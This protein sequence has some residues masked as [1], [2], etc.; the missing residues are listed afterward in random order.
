[1]NGLLPFLTTGNPILL[2]PPF[3]KITI[4][5]FLY[6]NSP[7]IFAARMN[8]HLGHL[9]FMTQPTDK[10]LAIF[11]STLTLIREHGFHGTPMSLIAK[12]AGVAAGTIYHHFDSKDTLIEELYEHVLNQ[13]L[14]SLLQ[15]DE[16]QMNYK[17]RFFNFFISHC[18][19]YMEHPTALFF[20]EQFVNSPYNNRHAV[21]DNERGQGSFKYLIKYGVDQQ[22]LK[23]VDYRILGS[24][25]LGCIAST[26][27][28]HLCRNIPLGK[29]ELEQIAQMVWDGMKNPAAT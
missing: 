18:L 4:F 6:L 24:L 23:P 1:V 15:S 28:V 2:L 21:Q 26:A 3:P 20:I 27:K 10:K 13:I 19:F 17:D 25:A 16:V 8:V 5:S 9:Y 22:Y 29:A 12:K 7:G 11:E 14:H